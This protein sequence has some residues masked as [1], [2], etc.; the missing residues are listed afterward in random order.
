M[1]VHLFVQCGVHVGYSL[2]A[3]FLHCSVDL[4]NQIFWSLRLDHPLSMNFHRWALLLPSVRLRFQCLFL[5][6]SQ[7]LYILAETL[8]VMARVCLISSLNIWIRCFNQGFQLCCLNSPNNPPQSQFTLHFEDRFILVW[9]VIVE[10]Y[11][12]RL[13]ISIRRKLVVNM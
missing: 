8:L 9:L 1:Y 3:I 6:F 4:S 12:N 5:L 10:P 2:P 13:I 11:I 7:R